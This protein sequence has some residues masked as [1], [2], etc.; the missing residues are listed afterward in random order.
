M[1]DYADCAEFELETALLGK[2]FRYIPLGT[3]S[4]YS[5]D[6]WLQGFGGLEGLLMNEIE[7]CFD[8]LHEKELS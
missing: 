8:D 7:S 2:N 3:I 4:C 6:L 1:T 5:H